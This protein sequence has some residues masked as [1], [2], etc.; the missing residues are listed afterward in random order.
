M[1]V[2]AEAAR[3]NRGL[4]V[5]GSRAH[6]LA[7]MHFRRALP[8]SICRRGNAACYLPQDADETR[9]NRAGGLLQS[10]RGAPFA[11]FFIS[12][13]F[14]SI[15]R[16]ASSCQ[17]WEPLLTRAH[18]VI[19]SHKNYYPRVMCVFLFIFLYRVSNKYGAL[20]AVRLLS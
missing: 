9:A 7:M 15:K 8:E 13:F 19:G 3:I 1:R 10:E 18:A 6:F 2:L 11:H 5:D 17:D 12:V 20:R 16:S 4:D 14:F